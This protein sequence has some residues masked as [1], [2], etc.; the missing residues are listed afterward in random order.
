M[1]ADVPDDFDL[2][3]LQRITGADIADIDV[4]IIH[5]DTPEAAAEAL[6]RHL[7]QMENND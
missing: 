3:K 4:G 5:A 2:N 6:K 7:E 1:L